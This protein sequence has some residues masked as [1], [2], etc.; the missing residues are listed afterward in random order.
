M[1]ISVPQMAA[2]YTF[3]N[4]SSSPI[5]GMERSV[6]AAPLTGLSLI[7]ALTLIFLLP[8]GILFQ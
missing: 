8:K 5:L 2:A 3:T 6:N 7:K 1:W 4:K